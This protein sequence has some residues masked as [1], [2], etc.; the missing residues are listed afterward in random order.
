MS[1]RWVQDWKA[2]AFSLPFRTD[3]W[4]G[5]LSVWSY[6]GWASFSTCVLSPCMYLAVYYIYRIQVSM[7]SSCP[8]PDREM[9][10][11]DLLSMVPIQWLG[12]AYLHSLF[13][14]TMLTRL[15]K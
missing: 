15:V 5:C 7:S 8:S 10:V 13:F 1:P 3:A 14:T 6:S 9:G 11:P 12:I 2:L 4:C